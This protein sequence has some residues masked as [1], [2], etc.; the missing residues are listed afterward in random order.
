MKT[1][2]KVN[3][4]AKKIHTSLELEKKIKLKSLYICHNLIVAGIGHLVI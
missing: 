3:Y 4:T 2:I 1:K